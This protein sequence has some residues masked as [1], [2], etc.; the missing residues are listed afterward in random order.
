VITRNG[1]P[2]GELRL[3]TAIPGRETSAG[4]RP[5]TLQGSGL[6][7]VL[8]EAP[9]KRAQD[10]GMSEALRERVRAICQRLPEVE[11]VI[12]NPLH[13]S[14]QVRGKPFC[15]YLDDHHGD[16]RLAVQFKTGIEGQEVLVRS[17]PARFFVPPYVGHRG[18]A[19][20]YLD[21]AP[22]DWEAVEAFVTESYLR[23]APKTLARLVGR[24]T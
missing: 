3:R 23:T 21:V 20:L 5:R 22:V 4:G 19:G 24:G 18:W 8:F 6:D 12:K 13:S 10:V 14:F 1:L 17:D 16:G 9:A 11:E 2:A 7:G 15:W